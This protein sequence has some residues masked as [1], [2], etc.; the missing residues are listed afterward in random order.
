MLGR[1]TGCLNKIRI[2]I[3]RRKAWN[4][5]GAGNLKYLLQWV[6]EKERDKTG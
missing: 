1:D 2:L 5:F 6:C 3:S 4:G